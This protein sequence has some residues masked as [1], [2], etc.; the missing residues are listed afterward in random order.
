MATFLDP[1]ERSLE[2]ILTDHGRKL[3]SQGKFRPIYFSLADDEVDY[4]TPVRSQTEE[5]T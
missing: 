2:I 3:L 5:E 4:K 1:R